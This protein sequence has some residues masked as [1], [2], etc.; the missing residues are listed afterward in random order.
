[1]AT[2]FWEEVAD[3]ITLTIRLTPKA[4]SNRLDRIEA[5]ADG[6]K[7]LRATVTA[8]PE[9]GKANTALIKLI[10]KKLRLPKTTIRLIAGDQSRSKRL[11]IS[12]D[13]DT[14]KS[15]LHSSLRENGITY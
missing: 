7:R 9:K 15:A 5:D 14:L 12:G 13:P 4:A 11:H 10:S 6:H 1:M 2:D 3:G 8:V